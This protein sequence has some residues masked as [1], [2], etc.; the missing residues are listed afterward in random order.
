MVRRAGRI[1]DGASPLH[2]GER[3][4]LENWL[5]WHR[6]TLAAQGFLATRVCVR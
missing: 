6:T 4:M 1:H 2:R 3:E 5:D